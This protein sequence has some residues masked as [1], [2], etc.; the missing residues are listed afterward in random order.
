MRWDYWTALYLRTHC[1]A[2]GLRPLSIAA[3]EAA[4]RQF[5]AF[6]SE[7]F[8]EKPPDAVSACDVL[9]YLEHLR[10][11][12]GNGDSAVNRALVV[13]RSFYRAIVAMGHLAPAAN[14]L[15]GFPSIKAA[16]RKLPVTLSTEEVERLLAR[17]PMS[18]FGVMEPIG[19]RHKG[20]S[21]FSAYWSQ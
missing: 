14:P 19:F 7:R 16:P 21:E 12:R 2:R 15:A 17:P 3:Y 20:A 9:E 10:K 6:L 11:E 18:S 13:L 4:L 1:V 8:G 5:R